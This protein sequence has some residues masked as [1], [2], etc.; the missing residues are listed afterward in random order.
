MVNL[1]FETGNP[2][3]DSYLKWI[4]FQP[5]L[6]RIYGCSFLPYHDYGRGG[7][8]WRDLWQDCLSLLILNPREVRSMILNSFAGVR[9]DGTNATIIGEKPGEFIA[10]RN[11]ITRVWMDHAYWPFVTTKLY[12]NQTG[13]LDI[14]S[15]NVAYFKD[16]Q[17]KRGTY[18]DAEWTPQYG[19]RQKDVNGHIYEGTIL[20]HLLLQNLCAFY[21]AGEHGIM[22]LRGA[23]WNDALDMAA[24]KGE[25]V[26]FTCAYI[27]NFRDL[28]DT[29]EKYEEVSGRKEIL[30]AKEMGVLI[31]QSC[32]EY[33]SVEKRNAILNNYVS[34]CVHNI[35]GE[36]I[37]VD[38]RMLVQDLRQRA[39]WYTELICAQEWV[40]DGKENGWFN[41]YYDNHGRQVEGC[42]DNNVRMMLTGQVFSIMGNVA[43]DTQIAAITK[44][45]DTYLYKKEV[46]GYRLNTDFKEEKFDL[47]RMFGF[48]Y[49]EKENGAVFSHMTVMY[50][51]ALYQRGFVKEGYKALY[52]LLEQA[53]DTPVSLMYPG[54]PE[55]FDAEGK[56]K[57]P[58]L[59]G[60]ASWYMM[61]M[62]TQIFGFRG[63]WGDL[64]LEP[65]ILLQQFDG[66]N[67][68]SAQFPFRGQTYALVYQNPD[69]KEYGEYQIAEVWLDG[70]RYAVEEKTSVRIPFAELE[71][72]DTHTLRVVLR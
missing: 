35:S 40:T 32:E 56:G 68:Y 13:D 50:A 52:T 3:E 16:P 70:Q 41:G 28:A 47:G 48:A 44:S 53:M 22:R 2:K 60:A 66:S 11:H 63:A 38:I 54:I 31:G 61:T 65:K 71:K 49:G 20:E 7:R 69:Q 62:V 19:M 33:D 45:A 15:Q 57:Y 43:D 12:L 42:I 64:V 5:V 39:D 10:D 8:G 29:L 14:L 36:Q 34:Q 21:E 23:D 37:S 18:K 4:C 24:G 58:Y 55:Y 67:T 46:G 6:R 27:G 9:F 26:A 59:T 30:L 25:S 17:A 51:N 72:K 1:S